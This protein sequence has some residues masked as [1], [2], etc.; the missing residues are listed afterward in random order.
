MRVDNLDG[1]LSAF[2]D[3]PTATL[4]AGGTA[5]LSSL[6]RRQGTGFV[7]PKELI[8]IGNVGELLRISRTEKYLDIGPVLSISKILSI[9]RNAIPAALYDALKTVG[10]PSVRNL[11]TLGGNICVGSPRSDSLPPLY[12]SDAVLEVRKHD[13]T[14]WVPIGDFLVVPGKV[15]L[16][17]G[18]VL[19]KIRIPYQDWDFQLFRKITSHGGMHGETGV[20]ICGMARVNRSIISDV[21]LSIGGIAPVVFRAYGIEERLNGMKLPLYRKNMQDFVDVLQNLRIRHHDADYQYKSAT[22]RRL[23][24]WLIGKIDYKF[25]YT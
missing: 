8:D 9:G 6:E 16:E 13:R 24:Y 15:M 21:R 19:T 2:R 10:S 12:A 17:P 3:H 7:L 20:S 25:L 4:F 23:V 1:L 18:E 14:R 22:V 11:A 5:V